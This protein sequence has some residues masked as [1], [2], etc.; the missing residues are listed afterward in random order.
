MQEN[1]KDTNKSSEKKK[2]VNKREMS[3]R[4]YGIASFF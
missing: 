2:K 1:N 3:K 4:I